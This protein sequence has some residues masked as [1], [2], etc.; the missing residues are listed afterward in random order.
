[1]N[2]ARLIFTDSEDRTGDHGLE[3]V[4]RDADTFFGVH[5]RKFR[6]IVCRKS[7][8]GK[9]RNAAL[10]GDFEALVNLNANG[11]VWELA[12]D[13]K[14]QP[15]GHNAGT[16]LLNVGVNADGNACFQIIPRQHHFDTRADQNALESRDGA[17]L[18]NCARGDGDGGNQLVFFTG[19]FHKRIPPALFLKE[20]KDKFS[21][22]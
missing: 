7:G 10:D 16:G 14:K 20:R 15:C 1:M 9:R 6:I 11:V 5:V 17:F 13:V 4:L 19:K 12:D 18:C 21:S 22:K 2:R 3:L 8:D